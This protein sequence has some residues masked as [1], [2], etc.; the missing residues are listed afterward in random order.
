MGGERR[1]YVCDRGVKVQIRCLSNSSMM[2]Y[3]IIEQERGRR[4]GKT[5]TT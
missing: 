3:M 2:I 4:G 1:M 5:Y